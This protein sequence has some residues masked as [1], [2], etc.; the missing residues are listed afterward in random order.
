M[1]VFGLDVLNVDELVEAAGVAGSAPPPRYV[2]EL[3]DSGG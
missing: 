2:S 1:T 3:S